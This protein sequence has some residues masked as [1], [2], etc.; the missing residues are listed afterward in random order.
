ML[1]FLSPTYGVRLLHIL[2]SLLC[3]SEYAYIDMMPQEI[4]L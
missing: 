4:T 1:V 2:Q 3:V